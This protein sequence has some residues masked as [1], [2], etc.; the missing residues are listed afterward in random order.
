MD[1]TQR[2]GAKEGKSQAEREIEALEAIRQWAAHLQVGERIT[3]ERTDPA[4]HADGRLFTVVVPSQVA[5]Q[6]EGTPGARR[7]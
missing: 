3:I 6:V 7:D 5:D 2:H 4:E 1:L